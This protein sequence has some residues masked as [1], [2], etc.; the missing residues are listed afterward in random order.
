MKAATK[1][2]E[3]KGINWKKIDRKIEKMGTEKF[4]EMYGSDQAAELRLICGK[5]LNNEKKEK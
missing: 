5:K 3:M 2:K 1:G 4:S